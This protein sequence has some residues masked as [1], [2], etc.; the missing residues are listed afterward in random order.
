[1]TKLFKFS[2]VAYLLIASATGGDP[3]KTVAEFLFIRKV[4]VEVK[5]T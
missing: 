4:R 1:M 2:M 5:H 3:S